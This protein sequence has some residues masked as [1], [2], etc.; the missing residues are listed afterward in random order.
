MNS[1]R[2][3]LTSRRLKIMTM[4]SEMPVTPRYI[5]VCIQNTGMSSSRSRNVPPPMA[6]TSP[7]T[8]APN[9]SNDL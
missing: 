6:V 5:Q 8:Y 2:S 7:T 3:L 4:A 1:M 9:Q